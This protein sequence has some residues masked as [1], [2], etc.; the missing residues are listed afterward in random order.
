M[1]KSVTICF[2]LLLI[3]SFSVEAQNAER[4]PY[5]GDEKY[6]QIR[7]YRVTAVKKIV[8]KETGKWSEMLSSSDETLADC[9]EFKPTER[10]VREFFLRARRISYRIYGGI[11]DASR[12]YAV[13]EIV[14]SNGDEGKWVID[15]FRRGLLT[16]SDGRNIYFYCTKCRGKVFYED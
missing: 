7:P 16:L 3:I 10:D 9:A 6:G 4:D 12:C 1:V 13:G 15:P 2:L 14:F 11:L 5:D 8:I